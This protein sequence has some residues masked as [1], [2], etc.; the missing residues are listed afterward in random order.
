MNFKPNNGPVLLSKNIFKHKCF[1]TICSS[2]SFEARENKNP[3]AGRAGSPKTQ[4]TKT[5]NQFHLHSNRG[6]PGN[7]I[8]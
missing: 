6:L 8:R 7:D 5:G 1:D 4:N 3:A 2:L